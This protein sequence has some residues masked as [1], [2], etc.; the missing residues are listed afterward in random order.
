M[1]LNQI[2]IPSLDVTKATVFYQ[3]LG[4]HLIVDASPRYVRFE[5]PDG[6]A[7]F[8]IHL[9][10]ELPKGNGVAVYFEDENLDE[11]VEK[12][13]TKGIQFDLMPTDQTWLWREARLKD[14]D[15]NQ[16]IF[17]KAGEHRKNPP[18]RI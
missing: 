14:L 7:T 6:G 2:T 17:Y 5:L 10:D 16:L 4:L 8:S 13:V 3:K 18:W 15:G 12:L 1:N 9:V 11:L